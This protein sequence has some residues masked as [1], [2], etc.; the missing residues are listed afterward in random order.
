MPSTIIQGIRDIFNWF[1]EEI[2]AFFIDLFVPDAGY[3]ADSWD[4]MMGKFSFIQPIR[5]AAWSIV[6]FFTETTFDV[7]PVIKINL[8]DAEG[9]YNYGGE[10]IV[11]DMRWYERYKPIVDPFLAAFMWLFFAWRLFN[12]IPNILNGVPGDFRA[13]EN[14]NENREYVAWSLRQRKGGKK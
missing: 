8:A 13:V 11:L 3:I 9:N 12:N 2:K 14:I 1:L 5:E 4:T 10:A 7:P 6:E